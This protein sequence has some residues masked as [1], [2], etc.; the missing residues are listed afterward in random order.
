[1]YHRH[2]VIAYSW[3]KTILEIKKH[4]KRKTSDIS[5]MKHKAATI[6]TKITT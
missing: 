6:W 1:M 2:D 5:R 4:L 3:T